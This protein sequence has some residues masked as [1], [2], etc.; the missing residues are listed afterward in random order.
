M[1]EAVR[2][3]NAFGKV[4]AQVARLLPLLACGRP[5]RSSRPSATADRSFNDTRKGVRHEH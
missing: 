4:T 1:A 3:I 2:L 5:R